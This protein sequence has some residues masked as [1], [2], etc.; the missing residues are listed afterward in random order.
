MIQAQLADINQNN[1]QKE[2]L[3]QGFPNFVWPCT[4]S[5][6]RYMSMYP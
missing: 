5:V 2:S 4:P 1:V 6:F 3:R